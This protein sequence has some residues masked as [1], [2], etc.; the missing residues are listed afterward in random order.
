MNYVQC[1]WLIMLSPPWLPRGA[2]ASEER[3]PRISTT[4][5]TGI[6]ARGASPTKNSVSFRL[7][8]W[9][10]KPQM[11]I[12]YISPYDSEGLKWEHNRT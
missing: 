3:Q 10:T 7:T 6:E 2:P 8:R 1:H 4:C 12:Y 11:D 5:P 9:T